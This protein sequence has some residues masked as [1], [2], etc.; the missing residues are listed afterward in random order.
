MPLYRAR[1]L[2]TATLRIVG[3]TIVLGRLHHPPSGTSTIFYRG[4]TLSGRYDNCAGS[5]RMD[6]LR[7]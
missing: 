6:A 5:G 3:W 1:C 2:S 4:G 7:F